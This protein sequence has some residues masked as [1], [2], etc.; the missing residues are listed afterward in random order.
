MICDGIYTEH[1]P[2]KRISEQR[3]RSF[4]SASKTDTV[5]KTRQQP[6]D[7]K[8][9]ALLMACVSMALCVEFHGFNR[10]DL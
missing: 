1:V 9:W 8:S 3:Q 6:P 5:L 4:S 10:S 2:L 7:Q